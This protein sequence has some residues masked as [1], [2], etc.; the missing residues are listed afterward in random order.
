MRKDGSKILL[1]EELPS[2]QAPEVQPIFLYEERCRLASDLVQAS[3][4][5]AAQLLAFRSAPG[6]AAS[7]ARGSTQPQPEE[8][9]IEQI[10]LIASDMAI[11]LRLIF[12]SAPFRLR[13][14]SARSEENNGLLPSRARSTHSLPPFL[15]LTAQVRLVLRQAL[16]DTSRLIEALAQS[17]EQYPARQSSATASTGVWRLG[18]A[19]TAMLQSGQES[20]IEFLLQS[21]HRDE[22]SSD[23][24]SV[25]ALARS[26][27]RPSDWSIRA[28]VKLSHLN[29]FSSEVDEHFTGSLY[30]VVTEMRQIGLADSMI[31][32]LLSQ[33][34]V[35]SWLLSRAFSNNQS[36]WRKE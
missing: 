18:V 23:T 16:G 32:S 5:Q 10:T 34:R 26:I 6:G 20:S 9:T 19:L 33:R 7:E 13:H 14:I 8:N 28:P 36:P 3:A 25:F 2:A 27:V 29:V 21:A 15:A 4:K 1:W 22:P 11:G 31:Q 12:T 17:G 24:P 35:P 30:R